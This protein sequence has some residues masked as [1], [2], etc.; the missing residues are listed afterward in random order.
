MPGV[1]AKGSNKYAHGCHLATDLALAPPIPLGITLARTGL[2]VGATLRKCLGNS[3]ESNSITQFNTVVVTTGRCT[4]FTVL[5]SALLLTPFPQGIL[6]H[7]L[8][9]QPHILLERAASRPLHLREFQ[10]RYPAIP[11]L[12][13]GP[14]ASV[15]RPTTPSLFE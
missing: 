3:Q 14:L 7:M 4:Y 8:P 15:F 10:L 6:T 11:G 5:G 13:Q 12:A 1:E 9:P 2:L